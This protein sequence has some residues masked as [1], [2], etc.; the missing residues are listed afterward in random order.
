MKLKL[1]MNYSP[2]RYPG[3]KNKLSPFIAELCKINKLNGTYIEPYC[4]GAAVALFLL[5]EGF[6]KNIIINDK[7]RSIFAFWHSV[8]FNSESLCDLIENTPVNIEEWKKQKAVQ[9]N[10]NTT[11]LLELGFSTFFLNRTNRSGILLAN[12]IGGINQKGNYLIDCRYNKENLIKRIRLL[13]QY[14]EQVTVKN[15]DAIELLKQV[16]TEL[17]QNNSLMY[18]DPPYYFKAS[19]LYLNHYKDSDHRNVRIELE[20]NLINWIV[21]YDNVMEIVD[22]FRGYRNK[23][24]SFKH[25][26][27]NIREGKEIIYFSDNIILPKNITTRNPVNYKAKRSKNDISIVYK[28][29]K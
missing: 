23:Q 6:V 5:V 12:P 26:A 3:G 14:K 16:S 7:D 17:E 18:L 19:S 20:N 8:F 4:G 27:Y 1:I 13:S 15:T 21:S 2:L 10:K 11:S 25:T 9:K 28:E 22:I 29:Q 24:F